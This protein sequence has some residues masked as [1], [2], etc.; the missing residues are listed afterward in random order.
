MLCGAGSHGERAFQPCGPKAGL[1]FGD[2]EKSLQ[3]H[4]L[5]TCFLAG[6][7]ILRGCGTLGVEVGHRARSLKWIVHHCSLLA[8][9]FPSFLVYHDVSISTLPRPPFTVTSVMSFPAMMDRV[10]R[11]FRP[12]SLSFTYFYQ[13]AQCPQ[14][15][16][17][18][19]IPLPKGS[20][21]LL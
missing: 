17:S 13:S 9:L 12:E 7:A 6:D 4:S 11:N 10:F 21:P 1:W 14:S 5:N 8:S 19:P 2:D 16:S 18:L 15:P 20:H 3:T